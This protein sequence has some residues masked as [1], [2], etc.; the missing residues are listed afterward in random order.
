MASK[1]SSFDI[2]IIDI[3]KLPV[4]TPDKSGSVLCRNLRLSLLLVL[5]VILRGCFAL[6]HMDFTGCSKPHRY[7]MSLD[8]KIFDFR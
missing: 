8:L 5:L 6:F 7:V 3:S 2:L 4:P 1:F